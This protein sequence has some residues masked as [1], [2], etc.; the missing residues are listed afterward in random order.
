MLLTCAFVREGLAV[1]TKAATA[2]T[3]GVAGEVPSS[4]SYPVLRPCAFFVSVALNVGIFTPGATTSRLLPQLEPAHLWSLWLIAP[5][6]STK[7][8]QAPIGVTIW[9]W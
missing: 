4:S 8:G 6:E 9:T 2:A 7:D 1:H 3:I 5:T